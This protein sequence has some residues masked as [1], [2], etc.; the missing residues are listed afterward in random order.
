MGWD[1]VFKIIFKPKSV[2]AFLIAAG[3]VFLLIGGLLTAAGTW[4]P[5][6]ATA[7]WFFMGF[8]FLFF[9]LGVGIWLLYV[10][11]NFSRK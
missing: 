2:L 3:V 6:L 9:C 5:G 7:A 8:G 11:T 1:N 4:E 10:F